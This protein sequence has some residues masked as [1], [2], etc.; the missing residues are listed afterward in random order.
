[1][2][3]HK[4]APS[5]DST[6]DELKVASSLAESIMKNEFCQCQDRSYRSL[7]VTITG[8][9]MSMSQVE[10]SHASV[11]QS[12]DIGNDGQATRSRP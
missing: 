10:E 8:T 12:T 3:W 1:M 7:V 5:A 9:T 11:D 4:G 2:V 6:P